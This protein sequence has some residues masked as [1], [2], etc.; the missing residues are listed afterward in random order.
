MPADD[1]MGFS[2]PGKWDGAISPQELVR[3][4]MVVVIAYKYLGTRDGK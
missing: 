4:K 2:D 3:P 1:L